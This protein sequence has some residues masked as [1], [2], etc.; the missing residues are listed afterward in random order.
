MITRKIA[1]ITTTINVPKLLSEYCAQARAVGLT[2]FTV[3]VIGDRK[4]PPEAATFCAELATLTN[5]TVEYFDC[6][7]QMEY[8]A[9]V[10][11][12][13]D[14]LTWNSIQR[15]N[16]G[17]L[18]AYELGAEIVITIDDDN[19]IAEDNYFSHY[20]Q[21]GEQIELEQVSSESGWFNVCSTL[22]ARQNSYFYHRGYSPAHRTTADIPTTWTKATTT[23]VVI[24]GFWLDDP[25]IDAAQRLTSPIEVTA[26]NRAENFALAQG[27]WSPFNSQNTALHRSI[28]PAYFLSP[29]M[30]RYDDIWASYLIRAI[31]DHLGHS[32]SFG[33]PMVRQVRNPH[34][35]FKDFE[36]ERLGMQMTD[37]VC[38]RL[39]KITFTG[40]D[41]T[42][43]MREI[44]TAMDTWIAEEG[45]WTEVEL[46]CLKKW[47]EGCDIWAES[48]AHFT[49]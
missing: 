47:R 15:R 7:R 20:A 19:F 22:A 35:Y 36:A 31:T 14:H 43:C 3:I 24:A 45:V 48:I 30:G 6:D 2:D 8:L 34:N 27:T 25:D 18:R 42:S 16:I 23:P 28:I 44:I 26:Y 9:A 29:Y 12:L 17:I 5:Y 21:L 49:R 39:R 32:I 1:L 13:R 4:T 41:Y 38:D 37:R 40:S 10:P 11:R 46:E 33:H